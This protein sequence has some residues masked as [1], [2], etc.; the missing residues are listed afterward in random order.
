MKSDFWHKCWQKNTIGFHQQAVHPFLQDYLAP[1]INPSDNHILV[2]LCGKSLDM[3]WLAE[4]MKVIGA[5][6]SEIACT[7]FFV[8]NNLN[9]QVETK[10]DFTCYHFDNISLWQGDFLKLPASQFEPFDWIYDRAA[11][12][13]LP[14][15]MQQKYVEH[16]KTFMSENTKLFLLTL[17]FPQGQLEG[18]PFAVTNNYV[19]K[20]FEGYKV[21]YLA[22]RDLPEKQFA[23]R[24]F[25]VDYLVEKLYMITKNN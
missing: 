15:A 25:D 14:E 1:L 19:H 5:E 16:V 23:Q 18:P 3:A 13:A 12:V 22:E 7:D 4:H 2:P 11:L 17:E 21:E 20:L 8:D 9:Y 24:V 10:G 6:L